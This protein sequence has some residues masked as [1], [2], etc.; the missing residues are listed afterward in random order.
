M[1]V[2]S[3]THSAPPSG[4]W[5]RRQRIRPKHYHSTPSLSEKSIQHDVA[6]GTI[7]AKTLGPRG[8]YESGL[9]AN[10][11]T[12]SSLKLLLAHAHYNL[13]LPPQPNNNTATQSAAI[14]GAGGSAPPA[15]AFIDNQRSVVVSKADQSD[16]DVASPNSEA[17][18]ADSAAIAAPPASVL[19]SVQ[20]T[21]LIP[22]PRFPPKQGIAIRHEYL[23]QMSKKSKRTG[24]GAA[25]GV[26]GGDIMDSLVSSIHEI[27]TKQ[28]RGVL[29]NGHRR[30]RS[31]D[32][33]NV[34]V[35]SPAPVIQTSK[36]STRSPNGTNKLTRRN[37]NPGRDTN[38]RLSLRSSN[39]H[40]QWLPP[41]E[42]EEDVFSIPS[43]RNSMNPP[44]SPRHPS[45]PIPTRS[46]S[47]TRDL[48]APQPFIPQRANS[49]MHTSAP[50]PII[51]TRPMARR[52]ET[53]SDIPSYITRYL[54]ERTESKENL[55]LDVPRSP[56]RSFNSSRSRNSTTII[57]ANDQYQRLKLV[58]KRQSSQGFER[59][60]S[61]T[62]HY[63]SLPPPNQ[64]PLRRSASLKPSRSSMGSDGSTTLGRVNSNYVQE[65]LS[66][67]KLTQRIRLTNGR[68]LSFSEVHPS[69]TR[70]DVRWVTRMVGLYSALPE[71]A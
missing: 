6:I 20:S 49:L 24:R 27:E 35:V 67:P 45:I 41:I 12:R 50:P 7:T 43:S 21:A 64:I 48:P 18:A 13:L 66:N 4:Q 30:D 2:T 10:S 3:S 70:S 60:L 62:R 32:F 19:E 56:R 37:R 15:A 53:T 26:G 28:M 23:L 65:V 9:V 11:T 39:S 58:T 17:A 5:Q 31:E 51:T 36:S 55:S 22:S 59:D 25:I 38:G 52:A 16:T 29:S 61:A 57:P 40:E 63:Y 54:R 34:I 71:W 47:I 14:I 42:Q 44:P 46:T 68:I 8:K 69:I 33:N 1:T